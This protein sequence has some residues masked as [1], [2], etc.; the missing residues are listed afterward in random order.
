M[1]RLIVPGEAP[2]DHAAPLAARVHDA[3]RALVLDPE[4]P[5]VGARSALNQG[6][7]RFA[8]Y[9]R[10]GEAASTRALAADLHDF[11]SAPPPPGVRVK[12]ASVPVCVAVN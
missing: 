5:C 6:G 11:A 1:P 3:F 4:F 7:Y 10:L 9:D 12:S 2:P 8:L